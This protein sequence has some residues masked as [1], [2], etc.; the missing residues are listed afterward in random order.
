MAIDA[1]R[2]V[3]EITGDTQGLDAAMKR[4]GHAAK[5]IGM[6]M[7]AAG[8]IITGVLGKAVSDF[9][10]YGDTVQKAALRTGLT[11]EAI[12]ELK[13][14]AEQSGAGLSDLET[15]LKR[16]A[17]SVQDARDGMA[18]AVEALDALGLS[19]DDFEGKKPEEAFYILVGALSKVPDELTQAAL[20]QEVFGRSG[21]NLLPMIKAG[22][23]G[24]AQMR[25]EAHELGIVLSQEDA[26]AAAELTDLMDELGKATDG[27]KLEIARGLVP[28]LKD[29]LASLIP[30]ITDMTKWMQANP[31]LTTT[32]IK[33]T[34]AA[35]GLLLILGP[36]V[37]SFSALAGAY[38]AIIGIKLGAALL[39]TAPAVTGIGTA[40]YFA[41]GGMGAFLFTVAGIAIAVGFAIPKIIQFG[42]ELYG[43]A[44]DNAELHRSG[45]RLEAQIEK[46]IK[47]L[48]KMGIAV[49]RAKLASMDHAQTILYLNQLE[50][51]ADDEKL[52]K[53]L[54]NLTTR[55][56]AEKNFAAFKNLM[57]NEYLTMEEASAIA[58]MDMDMKTK[59]DLLRANEA[60]TQAILEQLGMREASVQ[61]SASVETAATE[62][63]IATQ[64]AAA[65]AILQTGRDSKDATAEH[66]KSLSEL[67]VMINARVRE[68]QA[69]SED[70][71]TSTTTLQKR[72][73]RELVDEGSLSYDELA[74][75]QNRFAADSGATAVNVDSAMAQMAQSINGYS[76]QMQEDLWNTV[77]AMR[78][79]DANQRHS[80][81][82]NDRVGTGLADTVGLF[83]NAAK[84]IREK[85]GAT[86]VATGQ[87]ML[88]QAVNG[89]G[90][91]S[92]SN[93]SSAFTVERGAINVSVNGAGNPSQI[94]QTVVDTIER[95]FFGNL[96]RRSHGRGLAM[97]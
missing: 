33:V 22:A 41:A 80:P 3:W 95:G 65:E 8:G 6:A 5:R 57:L 13:H 75:A 42:Q 10:S 26:D 87:A 35:G 64:L 12:S 11:T 74:E 54:S 94:A 73:I 66:G 76:L 32:I 56:A 45:V 49:D 81:S 72:A 44:Q 18:S 62:D 19:V 16:Q 15:A 14:A 89:M 53:Y 58:L 29:L 24:L 79:L 4:A 48:E 67:N 38:K 43:L 96:Q 30:V 82:I 55:E 40:G 71:I 2:V 17:R 90:G 9:A 23:E 60:H 31:E 39:G 1:G 51:N 50:M 47:Q 88:N 84:S 46:R 25:E 83:S 85:L 20:A 36:L 77:E 21:T 91:G 78:A 37:Y 34:A 69:D 93:R 86:R 63:I 68:L 61:E 92:V 7:T 59:L 27:V 28:A 52:K 70:V 97:T